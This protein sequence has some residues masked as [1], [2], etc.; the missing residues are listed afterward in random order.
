MIFYSYYDK[1][2]DEIILEISKSK[3][4]RVK[5]LLKYPDHPLNDL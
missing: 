3:T 1:K 4:G 2:R 5:K